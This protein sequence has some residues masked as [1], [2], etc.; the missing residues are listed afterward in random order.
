MSFESAPPVEGPEPKN[1]FQ[2]KEKGD[3]ELDLE[4]LSD[5]QLVNVIQKGTVL[6]EK[7]KAAQMREMEDRHQ[8]LNALVMTGVSAKKRG[9]KPKNA[10]GD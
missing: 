2:K 4:A 6:W 8:R 5:E 7:R 1:R 9:R 10:A 3:A